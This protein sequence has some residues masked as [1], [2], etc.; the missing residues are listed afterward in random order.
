LENTQIYLSKN[1][2]NIKN[3]S[4]S[5]IFNFNID[6]RKNNINKD[7]LKTILEVDKY[8]LYD[9]EEINNIL[10]MKNPLLVKYINNEDFIFLLK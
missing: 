4:N 9:I 1:K 5:L 8:F 3:N 7:I 10:M 2:I 6:I